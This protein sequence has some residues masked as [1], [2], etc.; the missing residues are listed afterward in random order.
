MEDSDNDI[1][2]NLTDSL[3]LQKGICKIPHSSYILPLPTICDR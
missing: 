3:K 2:S 1:N